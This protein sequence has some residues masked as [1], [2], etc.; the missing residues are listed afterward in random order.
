MRWILFVALMATW[1]LP[2]IGLDGT[3]VPVFRYAQLA[4]S[5]SVLMAL[6]GT[7]GMVV[8]VFFLFCAHILIYALILFG[9]A[10]VL[11][12]FVLSKFPD[13]IRAVFVVVTVVALV[14][15]GSLADPYD[16]AFHHSDAHAPLMDLY[17]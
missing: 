2:L 3:L 8:A 7:G 5:L 16:S 1:P 14:S 11:V 15:W 6:E 13:R 17:R 10:S 4:T 12:K 9:V